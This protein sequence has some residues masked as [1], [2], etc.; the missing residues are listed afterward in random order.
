MGYLSFAYLNIHF[1]RDALGLKD[2][3]SC[4]KPSLAC[5]NNVASDNLPCCNAIF[6]PIPLVYRRGLASA[7]GSSHAMPPEAN[8]PVRKTTTPDKSTRKNA[9]KDQTY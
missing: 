3:I 5:C 8:I 4:R 7:N 6:T 2:F 9:A 1:D